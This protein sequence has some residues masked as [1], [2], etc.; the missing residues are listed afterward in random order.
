[1]GWI[2]PTS[3]LMRHYRK[4]RRAAWLRMRLGMA[5]VILAAEIGLMS[6]G[7]CRTTPLI[8]VIGQTSG[9]P[10]SL[11]QHYGVEQAANGRVRIYWNAPSRE[12]A[13]DEQIALLSRVISQ[14]HPDGIILSPDHSLALVSSARRAL[15][16]G[17]PLVVVGTS[18]E[19]SPEDN[20]AF[21]LND[22]AAGAR[23]AVDR[24][25][26]LLHGRGTIAIL[27]I[28]PAMVGVME[29]FRAVEAL[30][31]ASYPNIRIA[32]KSVG[33]FNV[34]REQQNAS[35]ILTQM[36]HPDAILALNPGTMKGAFLAL[37]E[38][39]LSRSIILIGFD[40]AESLNIVRSGQVDSIVVQN[41]AEMGRQAAELIL[42]HV[43]HNNLATRVLIPP[44]L[45]TSENV[46]DPM[47]QAYCKANWSF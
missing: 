39:R 42:Q 21:I 19:L 10:L 30:L 14:K 4:P 32:S 29:R 6:I 5:S 27:G 1:M 9:T 45:V 2:V 8:A 16:S 34:A 31:A 41:G 37:R 44:I 40:Q 43:E 20:L 47:I 3:R 15:L 12:D 25:A 23:L 38:M 46:N 22:E 11:A 7:A 33:S 17:I 26:R 36:P 24:L 28:D 35:E 18:V 13:V